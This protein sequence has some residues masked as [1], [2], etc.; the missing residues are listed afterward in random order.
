MRAGALGLILLAGL[1]SCAG[2]DRNSVTP[3]SDG[4]P[5]LIP[6]SAQ[7][8]TVDRIVDGD[9]FWVRASGSGPLPIG[10]RTKVRLLE[11]DTP[12]R[13]QCWFTQASRALAALTP[14]GSEVWLVADREPFD[15]YGRALRYAFTTHG[16]L[17]DVEMVRQG[18]GRALL[19]RPND[20][21]IAEI[22]AAEIAAK[23][24]RRG[25]WGAC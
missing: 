16:V 19:V 20:A 11:Y 24:A 7:R 9:T 15:R 21:H 23:R 13:G 12:E 22:D 4:R 1:T 25:L 6:A 5:A 10:V 18:M 2:A 8:A 17:V 14:V 3:S